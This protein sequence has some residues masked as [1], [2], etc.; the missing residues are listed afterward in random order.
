[1]EDVEFSDEFC[2]FIQTA[3]PAVTAAELL[4]LFHQRPSE[5]IT[6]DEAVAK[7]GITIADASKHL[8]L[9]QSRGL[10]ASLVD[11]H[12][13]YRPDNELAA[14]VDRLAEAY[15]QCPVT[16]FRVIYAFRDSKINR[17]PTPSGR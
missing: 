8:E 11:N 1:M 15:S 10:L 13:Q 4:L 9:F 14:H 17:S 3:I 7:P 6:V 12:Y 2:R 16:L 5:S